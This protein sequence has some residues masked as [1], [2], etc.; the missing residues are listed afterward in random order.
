MTA[1]GRAP[2]VLEPD[3]TSL[4]GDRDERLAL[5]GNGG[6]VLR[7]RGREGKGTWASLP[8]PS[9]VRREL[10]IEKPELDRQSFWTRLRG[11]LAVWLWASYL[12]TLGPV[13]E[14]RICVRIK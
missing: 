6:C 1:L 10:G 11:F 8:P 7:A 13:L 5:G 2:R 3:S 14:L 12:T 4:P 9:P